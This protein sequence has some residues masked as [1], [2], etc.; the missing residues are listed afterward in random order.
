MIIELTRWRVRVMP[1][2]VQG[3][4]H[5]SHTR[6]TLREA[7]RRHLSAVKGHQTRKERKLL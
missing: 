2:T 6:R 3:A 4:I 7:H 5:D 1:G